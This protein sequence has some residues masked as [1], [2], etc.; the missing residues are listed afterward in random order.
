[1]DEVHYWG[2]IPDPGLVPCGPFLR[3]SFNFSSVAERCFSTSN[4]RSLALAELLPPGR[5]LPPPGRLL[6]VLQFKN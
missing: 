4:T 3:C 1:M 2:F 6:P 5:L